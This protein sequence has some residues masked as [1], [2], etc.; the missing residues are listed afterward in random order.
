M[1]KFLDRESDLEEHPAGPVFF[2][3]L[4]AGCDSE[5]RESDAGAQAGRAAAAPRAAGPAD[6]GVPA[7]AGG[8]AALDGGRQ[9]VAV[10][11]VARD[12]AAAQ[13][14][15]RRGEGPAGAER[16]LRVGVGLPVR[17]RVPARGVGNA[18]RLLKPRGIRCILFCAS[19]ACAG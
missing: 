8:V 11:K 16:V 7:S 10:P 1:Q 18:A 17:R 5:R 15:S 14:D 2:F 9:A 3:S 12:G 19:S 4:T 13:L 6:G